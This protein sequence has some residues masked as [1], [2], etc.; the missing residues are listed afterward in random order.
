MGRLT[1]VQ[2]ITSALEGLGL[3]I[4]KSTN[5]WY[6]TKHPCSPKGDDSKSFAFLESG[7][8]VVY[9]KSQKGYSRDDCLAKLG[10]T[11]RDL[12]PESPNYGTYN[13]QRV[14]VRRD[15]LKKGGATAGSVLRIE[16]DGKKSFAQGSYVNGNFVPGLKE[17]LPLYPIIHLTQWVEEGREIYVNEGEKCTDAMIQAGYAACSKSGGS[18]KTWTPEDIEC[19]RGA[20]VVIVSD[21]DA[22]GY[23]YSIRLA[24]Q[25]HGVAKSVMIVEAKD[26]NDAYDHLEAGLS[27][28]DF[29][30]RQDLI[31]KPRVLSLSTVK[32]SEPVYLFSDWT[33][34]RVGQCNLLDAMGGSGKTSLALAIAC[35]GSSGHSPARGSCKKFVTLYHGGED[36]EGEVAA[37]VDDLGGDHSF[38]HMTHKPFN[39]DDGAF[40]ILESD[41]KEYGARFVVFD[42]VKY[43]LPPTRG[44]GSAE[45]DAKT[46]VDFVSRLREVAERLQVCILLVRHF[47][48]HTESYELHECGAGISQWRDSCRSQIVML[49]VPG[50]RG[51]AVV[52]HTK[53]SIRAQIQPPFGVGW[54]NGQY[55]FWTPTE[56]DF[57]ACGYN[58][59]GLKIKEKRKAKEYPLSPYFD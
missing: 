37:M 26:G 31:P 6:R 34:L 48:K 38:I 19:L 46:V 52:W 7:D 22:V 8:G 58:A 10:L 18:S 25:L 21:K 35:C 47:A 2:K 54:T 9:I 56:S 4:D 15:Y 3:K 40:E 42:A 44:G 32:P 39:M 27:A 16:S 17:E 57:K 53:G 30:V 14:A 51:N 12:Y 50:K 29:V 1:P 49:P 59:D 33:Y 45:F 24:K 41:I 28:E 11:Y 23:K 13:G 43:F 36:P 55:G 5:G 20:N